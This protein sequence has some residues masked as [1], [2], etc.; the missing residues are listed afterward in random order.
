MPTAV[1]APIP[2]PQASI[3]G[4]TRWHPLMKL[5][6]GDQ[7][8]LLGEGSKAA[9]SALDDVLAQA[10]ASSDAVAV[11][12]RPIIFADFNG[13]ST[14]VTNVLTHERATVDGRWALVWEGEDG[15]DAALVREDGEQARPLDAVLSR[16][17]YKRAADDSLFVLDESKPDA[18]LSALDTVRTSHREGIASVIVGTTAASYDMRVVVFKR[19]RSCCQRLFWSFTSVY[20][21]LR[22]TSFKHTPS[23]W[24]FAAVGRWQAFLE[25]TFGIGGHIVF[26]TYMR[27][28]SARRG[29]LQW[30]E[31]C[32]PSTSA[33]TAAMLLLLL[34][35]GNATPAGGGMQNPDVRASCSVLAASLMSCAGRLGGKPLVMY[36]VVVAK[37]VCQWPRPVPRQPGDLVVSLTLSGGMCNVQELVLAA[38]RPPPVFESVSGPPSYTQRALA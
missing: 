12:G 26:G 11:D 19:A 9:A 27:E 28:D 33:S 24:V 22:L 13:T 15:V 4:H 16:W 17:V 3:F 37:W 32:L 2:H 8:P 25:K 14:V 10:P 38:S 5:R 36:I 1:L 34:R 23:K 35:W 31:R 21:F 6:D 20:E 18:S 30:C 7:P 29:Q